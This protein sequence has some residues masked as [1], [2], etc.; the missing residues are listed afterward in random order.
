MWNKLFNR[1]NEDDAYRQE[2]SY[3]AFERSFTMP[4][5]VD[6]ENVKATFKNGILKLNIPI[7]KMRQKILKKLP[8]NLN[9]YGII[10]L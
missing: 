1:E 4:D 2:C 3:G 7:K 10:P 6:E 9:N 5:N 8:L